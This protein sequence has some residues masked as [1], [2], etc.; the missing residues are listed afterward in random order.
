MPEMRSYWRA[1]R[2]NLVLRCRGPEIFPF[3]VGEKRT[4]DL[5]DLFFREQ[6]VKSEGQDGIVIETDRRYRKMGS[7][8]LAELHGAP[9]TYYDRILL[10]DDDVVPVQDWDH[11]FRV[12]GESDARVGMPALTHDSHWSHRITLQDSTARWRRTNYLD[13]MAVL[14]TKT[15]Y[16]AYAPHFCESMH[17]WGIERMMGQREAGGVAILDSAPVRHLRP[18]GTGLC[19]EGESHPLEDYRA[20]MARHGL[21]EEPHRVLERIA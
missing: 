16:S 21:V 13:L 3:D 4:W 5:V 12:F 20:L 6:D 2:P 19:Y 18:V 10:L 8:R 17:L 14:L 1:R 15:A 7:I 11:V 9:I